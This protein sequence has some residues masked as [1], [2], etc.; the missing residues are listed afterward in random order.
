V[1]VW[2]YNGY[3]RLGLGNQKD[4]LNP[5][6]VPQV[7]HVLL[8]SLSV[9]AHDIFARA[10]FAGPNKQYLAAK[11]SAGPSN[12][13]VIDRQGMYYVAGKVSSWVFFIVNRH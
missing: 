11:I 7:S 2:G 13:V 1:Y 6:V 10:K 8:L 12:S 9:W 5:Q 3:C 4:V